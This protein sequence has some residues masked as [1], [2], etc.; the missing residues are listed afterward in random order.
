VRRQLFFHL[1]GA[2]VP[3]DCARRMPNSN[4][5]RFWMLSRAVDRTRPSSVERFWSRSPG[6]VVLQWIMQVVQ[7]TRTHEFEGSTLSG[8]D[9]RIVLITNVLDRGPGAYLR[10]CTRVFS[11]LATPL[12]M[13][14]PTN[15]SVWNA[16][17]IQRTSANGSVFLDRRI[18]GRTE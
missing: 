14:Q 5:D 4:A 11:K 2:K 3:P 12:H 10:G 9:F 18:H 16:I 17:L 13:V 15:F 7:G 6:P 1:F 8:I